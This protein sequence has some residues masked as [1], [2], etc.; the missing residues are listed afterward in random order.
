[1]F[2]LEK[3]LFSWN[4]SHKIREFLRFHFW[5]VSFVNSS[6]IY[7][8]HRKF[9]FAA[10]FYLQWIERFSIKTKESIFIHWH[11]FELL[12]LLYSSNSITISTY[13]YL[14]A[15]FHLM[16]QFIVKSFNFSG[17]NEINIFL[18]Y[19]FPPKPFLKRICFKIF[20]ITS[21]FI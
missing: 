17:V 2:L 21:K 20:L 19:F 12:P 14:S 4:A 3:S 8:D 13:G 11:I 9:N 7:L 18:L 6:W 10:S 15:T 1:M 5:I 16:I